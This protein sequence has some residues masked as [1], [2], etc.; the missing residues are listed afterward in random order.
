M[1]L[2]CLLR[3][4]GEATPRRTVFVEPNE[5]FPSK[6]DA[7]RD[8]FFVSNLQSVARSEHSDPH[9]EEHKLPTHFLR[10]HLLKRTGFWCRSLS[11][12]YPVT[13]ETDRLGLPSGNL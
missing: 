6:F 11:L 13:P 8:H 2:P 3:Q 4:H 1:N 7:F 12:E 10:P 9:P 5:P